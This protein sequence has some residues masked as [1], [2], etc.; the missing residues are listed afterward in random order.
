MTPDFARMKVGI[1]VA[2]RAR[3]SHLGP[4]GLVVPEPW[5]GI[6]DC[7]RMI[8]GHL[9]EPRAN[10][11]L[12]IVGLDA[13]LCGMT[14]DSTSLLQTLRKGL[15]HARRYFNWKEI[16]V[17]LLVDGRIADAEDDTGLALERG[18]RRWALAPMLGT[19]MHP[20]L[21]NTHGWWWAPQI[22]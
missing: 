6:L 18:A 7:L 5:M 22:G 21:A 19:H 9:P 10:Q 11:P 8:D 16:P 2:E 3:L 14:G 4:K 12:G 15:V 1:H 13:L 17:V 20:V